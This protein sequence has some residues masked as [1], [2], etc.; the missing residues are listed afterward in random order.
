MGIKQDVRWQI[1]PHFVCIFE[2]KG[3]NPPSEILPSP[4]ALSA[5]SW[6]DVVW[7]FGWRKLSLPRN[8]H[9]HLHLGSDTFSGKVVDACVACN[10]LFAA[11]PPWSQSSLPTLSWDTACANN[12]PGVLSN[13]VSTEWDALPDQPQ[14][15]STCLVYMR[16][17]GNMIKDWDIETKLDKWVK[18]VCST[19][20]IPEKK[21]VVEWV[22]IVTSHGNVFCR[23]CRHESQCLLFAGLAKHRHKTGPSSIERS[24][25][26]LCAAKLRWFGKVGMARTILQSGYLKKANEDKSRWRTSTILKG[27]ESYV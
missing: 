23:R 2:I 8:F 18:E 9:Q 22:W 11:S 17:W 1:I 21:V 4:I 7:T 12:S 24:V 5:C 20:G 27:S 10:N 14:I 19:I 3:E 16:T 26:Q 6:M 15:G 25:S 13:Y